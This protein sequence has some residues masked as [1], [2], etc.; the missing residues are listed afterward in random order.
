MSI[1]CSSHISK[2]QMWAFIDTSAGCVVQGVAILRIRAGN[3]GVL[4]ISRPLSGPSPIPAVSAGQRMEAPP[5]QRGQS[6][7]ARAFYAIHQAF[8][9]LQGAVS[10]HH[11]SVLA[12]PRKTCRDLFLEDG[13]I[14]HRQFIRRTMSLCP[15]PT[16]WNGSVCLTCW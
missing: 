4:S 5:T 11:I 13:H 2:T 6:I 15:G 1:G 12:S 7:D 3:D 16:C 14:L 9:N 10:S 8:Y